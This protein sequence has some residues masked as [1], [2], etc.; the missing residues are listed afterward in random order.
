MDRKPSRST[1]RVQFC[2]L[3]HPP[4]L[5]F[6]ISV[7]C[8]LPVPFYDLIR[9]LAKKH[10]RPHDLHHLEGWKMWKI[11]VIPIIITILWYLVHGYFCGPT[12]FKTELV[13]QEIWDNYQVDFGSVGYFGFLYFVSA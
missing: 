4:S 3:H 8:G 1:I 13:R 11:Y 2:P 5:S 6:C 7:H 12:E 9:Q 10:S